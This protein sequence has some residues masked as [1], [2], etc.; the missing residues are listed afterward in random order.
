MNTNTLKEVKLAS[1]YIEN[2]LDSIYEK[3]NL[4]NIVTRC[5]CILP[6]E[7]NNLCILLDKYKYLFDSI[8]GKQNAELVSLEVKSGS[9]YDKVNFIPYAL[10]KS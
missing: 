9:Y 4:D 1:K 8:L 5:T 2:I 7:N 10:N 3:A 6:K